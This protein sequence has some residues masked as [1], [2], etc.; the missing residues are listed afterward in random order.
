MIQRSIPTD[1]LSDITV[2]T[3]GYWWHARNATGLGTA[4]FK[5]PESNLHTTF[6]LIQ[7]TTASQP[8]AL[9]ENNSV[10]FRMRKA[11][12]SNP[13]TILTAGAVAAGWTGSTCVAGWFRLPDASG[14]LSGN[15][16][17]FQHGIAAGAQLR[18]NHTLTV[19]SGLTLILSTDGTATSNSTYTNPLLGADWQFLVMVTPD[20]AGLTDATKALL[21]SNL[22]LKTRT[23]GAGTIPTSIAN[24]SAK[25]SVACRGNNSLANVDTIDWASVFYCNGIPSTGDL[26]RM[27]GYYTPRTITF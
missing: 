1:D 15:G 23:G 5:V 12:D 16:N 3:N 11:A 21:Y 7:A 4:Q 6:D 14:V 8:T 9:A 18:L 27:A 13:S 2:L 24:S 26:R 10:Q 17:V 22:A 19:A 20:A 25:I